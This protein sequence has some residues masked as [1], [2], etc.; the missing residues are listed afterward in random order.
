M[1]A[2]RSFLSPLS[3]RSAMKSI[4][5]STSSSRWVATGRFSSRRLCFRRR[6]RRCWVSTWVRWGSWR[7]FRRRSSRSRSVESFFFLLFD[8]DGRRRRP[9]YAAVANG[10]SHHSERI[11]Q[12]DDCGSTW[13]VRRVS[14][15]GAKAEGAEWHR[16]WS[17]NVFVDGGAE[18]LYRYFSHHDG[19][20][21][22]TDH[23][24]TYW[25]HSLLDVGGRVD[26]ASADA[27]NAN[28]SHLPTYAFL[29]TDVV[30]R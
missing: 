22:R 28:D 20:C 5:W 1:V 9:P 18:L 3:R 2:F 8:A 25:V 21:R 17:R 27:R 16:D 30:P 13:S 24:H 19:P 15:R 4:R 11:G 29:P 14:S 26:G 7:P 10:V 12:C 23:R 6:C